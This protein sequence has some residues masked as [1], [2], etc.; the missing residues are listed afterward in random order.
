MVKG[1]RGKIVKSL[2]ILFRRIERQQRTLPQWRETKI[3]SIYKGC[4]KAYISESRSGTFLVNIISKMYELVKITHNGKNNSKIPEIQAAGRKER[5]AMDN[6]IIMN[7]IIENQ[8]VQKAKHVHVLLQTL[9][10][11]SINMLKILSEMSK[12][13]DIITRAPVGNTENMQEKEGVKQDTVFGRIMCFAE[14]STVNSIGVE[15][16]YRYGKMNIGMP[17]FMD[18]IATAGKTNT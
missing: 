11:A 15:V 7:T 12:E 8:R 3:K 14:T 16:K 13:T 17:V 1:K 5:S 18:D 6:L 4:N 10:N 9:L 2:S